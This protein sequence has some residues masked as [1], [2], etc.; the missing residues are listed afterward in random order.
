MLLKFSRMFRMPGM[1]IL[2]HSLVMSRLLLLSLDLGRAKFGRPFVR[3]GASPRR[4]RGQDQIH[5]VQT[6][7]QGQLGEMIIVTDHDP[8]ADVADV[9]SRDPVS[10]AKTPSSTNRSTSVRY[11]TS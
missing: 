10:G 1:T 11:S 5:L 2:F 3:P 7:Q 4:V 9:K 8:K 6:V